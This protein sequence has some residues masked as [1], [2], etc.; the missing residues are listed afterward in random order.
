[1]NSEADDA[2]IEKL[3]ESIESFDINRRLQP[4]KKKPYTK[5]KVNVHLDV[6]QLQPS[7]YTPETLFIQTGI[8]CHQ[9]KPTGLMLTIGKFVTGTKKAMRTVTEFC[10]LYFDPE[11]TISDVEQ[12]FQ[13]KF[14]GVVPGGLDS[15]KA[16]FLQN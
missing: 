8:V 1:M 6:D 14:I 12:S 11:A 7:E 3:C 5:L 4:P 13:A 16:L 10:D 15:R 9:C 2:E